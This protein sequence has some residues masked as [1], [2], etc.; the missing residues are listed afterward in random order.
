MPKIF[1]MPTFDRINNGLYFQ[2]GELNEL[3]EAEYNDNFGF[4]QQTFGLFSYMR[5]TRDMTYRIHFPQGT[6]LM[7]QPHNSCAWTPTGT[8]SMDTREVPPCKAKINEQMCYDEF[9]DSTY[10]AF[11]AWNQN[12]T[13][14]FSPEG[15]AATDALVRT[16]QK[17]ATLGHRMTLTGGKLHNLA[18]VT[19]KD[20]TPT[21]IEEA[22]RRTAGTCRGWIELL[23]ETAAADA[24]KSH[25][26]NGSIEAGDI[27]SDGKEFTGDVM[28]L[29]DDQYDGAPQP[30]QDAI[31]QGGVGGYSNTFYS[32]WLV[33]P[34]LNRAVYK[35]YQAQ[36]E[37][38]LQNEPRIIREAFTIQTSRGARQIFVFRIDDTYVI[39]VDEIAEFDRFLTGTSHFAYRTISGVINL[40]S[41]YNTFATI[42]NSEVAMMIQQ[43]TNAE[44]YGTYKFL[45]H[46]LMA[47][48]INDTDYITGD[49]LYAEPA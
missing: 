10:R 30:L 12:P 8:L 17:N 4:F 35:A 37:N 28:A 13:V 43:S 9:M 47:T 2:T 42:N 25:L 11:L 36:K 6:P 38:P 46:S 41:N 21:R 34:S 27:S 31:A 29:F 15:Q 14:G 20:G 24:S 26:D 23:I 48:A 1:V 5:L 45:A 22:F 40:G 7:W 49:Y 44:D 18:N 16:L 19:F 3:L 39:P 33:S 32:L